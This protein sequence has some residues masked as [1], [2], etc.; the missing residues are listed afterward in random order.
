MQANSYDLTSASHAW[1]LPAYYNPNWWKCPRGDNCSCTDE[2]ML[3]ILESV[4]FVDG[5]KLPPYVSIRTYT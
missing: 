5:V 3:E 2:E 1:I 4:I